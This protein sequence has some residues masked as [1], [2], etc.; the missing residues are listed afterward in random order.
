MNPP[1]RRIIPRLFDS[2]APVM[3]EVPPASTAP[4]PRLRQGIYIIPTLITL[5]NMSLGFFAMVKAVSHEFS[6]AATAIIIGHFLDAMDGKIA[7]WTGTDS[8]FGV[9][10]DSLADLTT[11]CIAPAFVMYELVLKNN[12]LWGFPLALLYVICGAL[13]LARFNMKAMA[14]EP[15]SPY[16]TGLPSPAAGGGC[17]PSWRSCT[18]S[19]RWA[20]R[21]AR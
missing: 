13:R 11:F 8:K 1:R 5:G 14:G 21:S 2:E 15:K 6:A 4:R 10:L 20:G 7:R 9:E 19:K 18:T 16:F 17:W 3:P 12:H